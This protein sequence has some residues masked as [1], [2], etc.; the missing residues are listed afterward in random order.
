MGRIRWKHQSI[1]KQ[2]L[3]RLECTMNTKNR[4]SLLEIVRPKTTKDGS[5]GRNRVSSEVH[6]SFA[7][8]INTNDD[9]N[10]ATSICSV[11]TRE[12]L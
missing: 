6:G 9:R 4:N 10:V 5:E 2:I 7:G 12:G 8:L 1:K 3:Q 11:T